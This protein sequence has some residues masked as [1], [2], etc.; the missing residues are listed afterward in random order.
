MGMIGLPPSATAEARFPEHE[1]ADIMR[2][3]ERIL[4]DL[5]WHITDV[6]EDYISVRTGSGI[7][8]F[9]DRMT[10][11]VSRRGT[12]MVHSRCIWPTQIID[13]G[14]NDANVERF[15]DRL[16]R[17]LGRRARRRQEQSDDDGR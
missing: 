15:L 11:E 3:A 17:K 2:V 13:F 16:E 14:R 9:G 7:W 8:F 5:G 4:D 6:E 1:R 12:V 10:V